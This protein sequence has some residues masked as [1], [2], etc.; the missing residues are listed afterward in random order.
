MGFKTEFNWILKL[1]KQ[2]GLDESTLAENR[3]YEFFKKDH[4]V[5]PLDTPIELVD[6]D[7]ISIGLV[8]ILEYT[9]GG[10]HTNGKYKVLEIYPKEKRRS[11]Q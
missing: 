8:T 9:V 1:T 6:E 11:L 3:I 7:W 5:Y 10:G 4:R 2:Q